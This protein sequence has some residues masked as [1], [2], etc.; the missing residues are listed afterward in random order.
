MDETKNPLEAGL[1]WITKLDCGDFNG[2]DAI[3][4]SKQDGLKR[5]L[6]GFITDDKMVA[7]HGQDVYIGN[8]KIGQVASGAPS[9]ML[10]KNIG[11]AYVTTE[12]S[13]NGNEIEI[14]VRG[15][16]IKAV[17]CKTPFLA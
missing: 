1:A 14:D 2:K 17:V 11:L 8:E 3:L 15:K 4:K 5:K 7:R 12:Y 9:P 16:R 10:G 13:K 6:V